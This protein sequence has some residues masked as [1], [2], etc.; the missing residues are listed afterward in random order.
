MTVL[1][2]TFPVVLIRCA[3]SVQTAG[4]FESSATPTLEPLGP[5]RR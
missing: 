1:W 2:M 5:E 4:V 3:I